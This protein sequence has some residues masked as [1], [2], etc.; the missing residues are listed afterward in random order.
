M[1]TISIRKRL[2]VFPARD[3]KVLFMANALP[4]YRSGK[5]DDSAGGVPPASSELE[6][7]SS[8]SRNFSQSRATLVAIP[9]GYQKRKNTGAHK[10]QHE[11]CAAFNESCTMAARPRKAV[12]KAHT[13]K[14]AMKI[15]RRSP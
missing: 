14:A 7:C 13:A 3:G 11:A 4:G 9:K 2:Q 15:V 5:D 8:S 10:M 12:P 1:I 6:G